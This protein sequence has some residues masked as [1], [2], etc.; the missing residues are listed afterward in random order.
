MC[1]LSGMIAV[2]P[3]CSVQTLVRMNDLI[4]HRGPDDEG[5][6]LFGNARIS[7]LGG[8]E[9][10]APV[11][12]SQVENRPQAHWQTAVGTKVQVGFGHRRLSILDLS[13]HGHQ[14]ACDASRRYWLIYNGE[15]YNF[16]ELRAELETA[17]WRFETRTDTEVVLKAYLAWGAECFQ[18]FVGMW[19]L[20]IYDAES[21]ELMLCRDRFGIK[22]LYY[23]ISPDNILYFASEIK[24]FTAC[25]GWAAQLNKPMAWDYLRYSLNDHTEE[26]M[27][28]GVYRILPG[29]YFK[30][31]VSGHGLRP[32]AS[33]PLTK[34]YVLQPGQFRGSFDDA[35]AE[36]NDRFER[37]IDQHLL[38]DVPVGVALSGGLDSS[39]ITC[40]VSKQ[41]RE[42]GSGVRLDSFSSCSSNPQYD[43]RPWID[44]VTRA[45]G[46][47][48]HC[49]YVSG[50]R[51]FE[52]TADL[53]W[54]QDEPYQSQSTLLGH[55]VFREARRAGVS[56]LLNGQ[57]A[58]EYLSC[59][60]Q[61]ANLRLRRDL[62]SLRLMRVLKE[63][64]GSRQIVSAVLSELRDRLPRIAHGG[65]MARLARDEP[66]ESV[67][68]GACWSDPEIRHPYLRLDYQKSSAHRISHYQLMHDP[69][70]RY[71]RWED[72]NSMSSSIEARVPF[73]D[74]RLVELAHSLPLEYLDA[75]G[76]S[77]HLLVES[78][79]SMLPAK[80]RNR[81]NKMGFATPERDW[82][83]TEFRNEFI[84]LFLQNVEHAQSWIDKAAGLQFL[85]D[86]QSGRTPF[87]QSY[88]RI[89]LFCIWMRRFGVSISS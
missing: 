39:V 5:Y 35:T 13:P 80:V 20:A 89:I 87:D 18:R 25:E 21:R 34:W 30:G 69:L 41:L 88:W 3:R 48:S 55:H 73:L 62:R 22:P 76:R 12:E 63:R 86:M 51:V 77:K 54:T 43:E 78:M 15:I 46:T 79:G 19:A 37:A 83:M 32:G 68:T 82:F 65:L 52:D 11:W 40:C 24:Q 23:W 14:P 26:T 66:L 33:L 7:T 81:Q 1:G 6:A 38:A 70:Q 64:S 36:F 2:E 16:R 45:C 42:A 29:H 59:Y 47:K 85:R 8:S 75:P 84:D 17:G 49:L 67:I 74:H 72:R 44:E 10:P 50:Q 71:L 56:V 60:G 61:Y 58:D 31:S 27:F 53:V 4:R 9:T 57:G 28:A